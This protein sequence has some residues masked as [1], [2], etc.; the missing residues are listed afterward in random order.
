MKKTSPL[1]V[2]EMERL[3]SRYRSLAQQLGG[4][5]SI[6]QGSVM[7][8][9]PRAWMWTRKVGGKTVTRGL[10]PEKAEKMKCAIASYREL[11]AILSEMR[12]ISQNLILNA[13]ETPQKIHQPKRPNP[14]L[15]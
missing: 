3:Q 15:S 13:P 2:R 14:A 9:P 8:Q 1:S 5:E 4:F 6:S 7:P 12:E 11:V 10:S